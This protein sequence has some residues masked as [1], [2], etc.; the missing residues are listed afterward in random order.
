VHLYRGD[1]DAARAAIEAAC[2]YHEPTNIY[3]A[4]A[5]R[6]VIALRQGEPNI[7][8]AAFS[9]ALAQC[10]ALLVQAAENNYRVLFAKGLA[11]SGLALRDG[12][13]HV[14]AAVQTYR[15][16]RAITSAPGIISRQLRLFDALAAAGSTGALAEARAALAGE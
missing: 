12:T 1:L 5:L 7:T 16:A 3:F 6:G 14:S 9:D 4:E 11:L 10:D 2:E 8:R 15:A 13:H